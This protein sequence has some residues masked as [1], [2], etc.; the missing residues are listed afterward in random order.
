MPKLPLILIIKKKTKEKCR[1]NGIYFKKYP[2]RDKKLRTT[3]LQ[4]L[5]ILLVDIL[6]I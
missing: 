4:F 1:S 5:G 3:K 2:N 6:K